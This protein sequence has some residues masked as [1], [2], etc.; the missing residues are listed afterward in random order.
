MAIPATSGRVQGS[1]TAYTEGVPRFMSQ[2]SWGAVIAGAIVAVTIG[3]MLNALGAG[4]GA[5]T[6][7]VGAGST[8]S[9]STFGIGAAI[10]V[11]ISTL[12]GLAVGGYVAARLSG[13]ADNTDGTLH[14]L[15]VW[16]TTFL[17]SAVLLGNL[18][19]GVASTAV[20]GASS[21]VGGAAQ[22]AGSLASAA[23]Q[24]AAN[25]TDNNSLQSAAQA[26]TSRMQSALSG[27]G[28]DPA[29]MN[30]DQR[31]AEIGRLAARRVSDGNLSQQDR[32]RLTQLVAAEYG[33][34]Q[35]EAQQR[36]QQADQQATQ[37]AQQVKDTATKAADAT[38]TGTSAGAF[39]VFFSMLLGAIASVIGARR[40]TRDILVRTT[41][42]V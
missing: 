19:A 2:V 30:S 39:A 28:G 18:V 7:D 17:I 16:G 13:T 37:A 41:R 31:K 25:R 24:Q 40:G 14:G 22:G 38:A 34:S 11:L 10:W 4:V 29:S 12:I 5:T 3:L 9:A 35:Q 8:P 20:R 27:Q 23:G 26:A 42:T 21:I 6:V 1:A 33:I 32:D 15:A 36:V